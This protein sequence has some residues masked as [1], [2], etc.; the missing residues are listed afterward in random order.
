MAT[1]TLTRTDVRCRATYVANPPSGSLGVV[2]DL[3]LGHDAAEARVV[4]DGFLKAFLEPGA[5]GRMQRL[6]QRS[7][8]GG[9]VVSTLRREALGAAYQG[10]Q[11]VQS[12]FDLFLHIADLAAQIEKELPI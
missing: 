1:R 4:F 2:L 7:W 5:G 9:G 12:A 3:D 8:L 11:I 10:F 6:V